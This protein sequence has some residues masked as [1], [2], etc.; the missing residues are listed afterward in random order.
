MTHTKRLFLSATLLMGALLAVPSWAAS[1]AAGTPEALIQNMGD[2]IVKTIKT[3]KAIAA[4][5]VSKIA[6]YVDSKIMPNVDF[7]RMT[8]AVVGR[9]Y[10]SATADQKSQLQAQYKKLIIRTYSGALSQFKNE[11]LEVQPS[12]ADDGD[13]SIVVRSR[14][15]GRPEPIQLDYRMK[16]TDAG[17][18]KIYD[19][20]V[21]GVWMND[22]YKSQFAS[23][24]KKGGVDA[25][26]SQLTSMNNAATPPAKP[27]SNG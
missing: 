21:A 6:S 24:V 12:K 17:A 2:D 4:G 15:I 9:S 3:D 7:D 13:T 25:L 19:V 18:W 27:G 8:G 5:D 1:F 14:I 11:T 23:A 20:N 10:N 22:S 16:K 26:I